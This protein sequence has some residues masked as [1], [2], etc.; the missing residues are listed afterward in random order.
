MNCYEC[1]VRPVEVSISHNVAEQ[2]NIW[3]RHPSVQLCFLLLSTLSGET[4]SITWSNLHQPTRKILSLKWS[5]F[6]LAS[7]TLEHTFMYDSC[8]PALEVDGWDALSMFQHPWSEWKGRERGSSYCIYQSRDTEILLVCW[9]TFDH[10][11]VLVTPVEV[12]KQCQMDER[13][14]QHYLAQPHYH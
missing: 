10:V 2:D 12:E 13:I 1:L 8:Q 4:K 3:A 7:W 6:S 11:I 9:S 14:G 5:M